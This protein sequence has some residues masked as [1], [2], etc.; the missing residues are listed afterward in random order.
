MVFVS[1]SLECVCILELL[2]DIYG[3]REVLGTMKLQVEEELSRTL[4]NGRQQFTSTFVA[5]RHAVV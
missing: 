1:S 4:W 2:S 5:S 3:V